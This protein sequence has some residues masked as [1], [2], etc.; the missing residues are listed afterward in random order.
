KKIKTTSLVALFRPVHEEV[1]SVKEVLMAE[2][3]QRNNNKND[4]EGLKNGISSEQS[5]D[6]KSINEDLT[7]VR[8][9]ALKKSKKVS[10]VQFAQ[11][12]YSRLIEQKVQLP[13][14]SS[15]QIEEKGMLQSK[16]I[17][18]KNNKAAINQLG[19]DVQKTKAHDDE[20]VF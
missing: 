18:V 5:A 1:V 15:N 20:I 17:E 14:S 16:S 9:T 13:Q 10:E 11:N 12:D 19:D 3:S 8:N 7:L 4:K 2:S 6:E